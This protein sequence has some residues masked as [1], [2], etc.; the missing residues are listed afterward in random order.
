M[1]SFRPPSLPDDDR[2]A[3]ILYPI[4][5]LVVIYQTCSRVLKVRVLESESESES[6]VS[7]PSPS[8]ESCGS[9]PSPSHESRRS[10]PSHESITK[11]KR[12]KKTLYILCQGS[13]LLEIYGLVS[14]VSN[15]IRK[16]FEISQIF[17]N[18]NVLNCSY[19]LML[20]TRM[21]YLCFAQIEVVGWPGEGQD[22][23]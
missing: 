9:S 16:W 8:P 18:N 6:P 3:R 17:R 20:R 7:S 15:V 11:F 4:I 23:V 19:K 10:S 21:I 13:K 12:Q 22:N 2:P 1:L 5:M 14:H